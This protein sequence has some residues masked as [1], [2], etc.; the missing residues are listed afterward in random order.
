[1]IT[2]LII[3]C[4]LLAVVSFIFISISL[5]YAKSQYHFYKLYRQE[6]INCQTLE[7]EKRLLEKQM[8]AMTDELS[9][10]NKELKKKFNRLGA[11]NMTGNYALSPYPEVIELD[12]KID[13][14]IKIIEEKK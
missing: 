13:E 5:K 2:A 6:Q 11:V 4:L 12:K 8:Q 3:V 9:E 7:N 14:V 1:M 10:L